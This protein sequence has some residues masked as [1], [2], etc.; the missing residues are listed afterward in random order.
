MIGFSWTQLGAFTA[1]ADA[2]TDE[3]LDAFAAAG[4]RYVVP[5]L[6]QLGR[7]PDDDVRA[8]RAYFPELVNRCTT[9][10]IR[11]GSWLNGW[12]GDPEAEALEATRIVK[13]LTSRLLA[14]AVLD[15]EAAYQGN[16]KLAQLTNAIR[17]SDRLPVGSVPI[18]VSTNSL[19]DS[20]VYNGRQGSRRAVVDHSFRTLKIAALPQWY[21]GEPYRGSPWADPVQ[22]ATWIKQHGA[23]DNFDD[24]TYSDR[25]GLR[26]DQVH[27]SVES[28]G[29]EG[30]RLTVSL[31][32]VLS[33]IV[34]VGIG[35]GLLVYLL[36]RTPSS[37][38][39]LIR[40]YRGRV[41]T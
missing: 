19:N 39:E 13:S 9:R 23:E 12:G 24:P 32:A 7:D 28:T 4:G 36:E 37:D 41:Y 3:T 35:K 2:I 8:N 11:V 10:G 30:A 5:L 34:T 40:S 27:A 38:F 31:A 20:Q 18:G 22:N 21:D 1:R 25:R 33:A 17:R 6:A 14:P 16:T 26:L 29:I 15:L